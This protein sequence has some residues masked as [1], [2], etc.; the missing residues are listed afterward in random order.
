[1]NERKSFSVVEGRLWQLDA[2]VL[3]MSSAV[4]SASVRV[5]ALRAGVPN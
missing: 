1:M 4:A 2:V 5:H 3:C